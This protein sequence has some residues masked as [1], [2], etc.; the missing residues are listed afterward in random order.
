MSLIY[1]AFSYHT[2]HLFIYDATIIGNNSRG[3][4]ENVHRRSNYK[5]I[6]IRFIFSR[7]CL[8]THGKVNDWLDNDGSHKK[9]CL[10]IYSH[11]KDNRD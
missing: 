7:Q 3:V 5:T 2:I 8:H 4:D 11:K 10:Y 9:I 6:K 1:E